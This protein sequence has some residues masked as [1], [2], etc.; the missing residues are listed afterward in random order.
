MKRFSILLIVLVVSL[1]SASL[2]FADDG[3]NGRRGSRGHGVAL[4]VIS[5]VTGLE[6][7]A[8][9]EALREEGATPASVIEA[10]GGSVEDVQAQIVAQILRKRTR[11]CRN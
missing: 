11:R 9:I 3:G 6:R 1:V 5:E 4:D 7:E 10:N 2:A 8:L